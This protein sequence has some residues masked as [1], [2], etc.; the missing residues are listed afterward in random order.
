MH[1]RSLKKRDR[2]RF[3]DMF[4]CYSFKILQVRILLD[5]EEREGR[6]FSSSI[7]EENCN[8]KFGV[9]YATAMGYFYKFYGIFLWP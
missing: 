3:E 5:L 2:V 9:S 1:V 6:E 7:R 4:L 8:L